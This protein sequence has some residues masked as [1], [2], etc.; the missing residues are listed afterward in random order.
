MEKNN[1][2]SGIISA[3]ALVFAI[4][5]CGPEPGDSRFEE[6]GTGQT[7]NDGGLRDPN[8][9]EDPIGPGP[10]LGM[11]P[12]DAEEPDPGME[13]P[14]EPED[15]AGGLAPFDND[16]LQAPAIS[17]LLRI[18]G[19]RQL[20]YAD[21]ISA[22]AGDDADFI[23][24]QLPNAS[25]PLQRITVRLDCDFDLPDSGGQVRVTLHEDGELDPGQMVLCNEGEQDLTVDNTKVQTA[26][27]HFSI[28][29]DFQTRVDYELTIIG[30][31]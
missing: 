22:E 19:L 12:E 1:L 26:M 28:T 14:D 23:E 16:S 2:L 7:Q 11:D 21:Q 25:N 10:D 9:D 27:V 30:F 31:R 17:E 29:P 8:E 4:S 24:F 15:P 18:T 13:P 6:D 5:A 3:S 20:A